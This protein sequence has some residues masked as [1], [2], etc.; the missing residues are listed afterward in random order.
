MDE[1][2]EGGPTLSLT[3]GAGRPG[4]AGA[5]R[6]ELQPKRRYGGE[7]QQR[8]FAVEAPR[9]GTAATP[10]WMPAAPLPSPR[11]RWPWNC[12]AKIAGHVHR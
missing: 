2:G 12:D 8:R 10:L 11:A 1:H 7:G 4:H 6:R 9:G 5:L 3:V